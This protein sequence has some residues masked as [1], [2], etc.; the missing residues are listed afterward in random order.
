MNH[1]R[2]T[3]KDIVYADKLITQI[4]SDGN[5]A[6]L[7]AKREKQYTVLS[8]EMFQKIINKE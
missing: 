7:G 2:G 6:P 1:F 8:K 4:H 3:N 5:K